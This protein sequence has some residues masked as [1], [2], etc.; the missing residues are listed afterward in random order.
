MNRKCRKKN[1]KLNKSLMINSKMNSKMNMSK[2]K[3]G[4]V[5]VNNQFSN[6]MVLINHNKSLKTT[7]RNKSHRSLLELRRI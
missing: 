3:A 2:K 4:L 7:I 5:I 1:T 6:K